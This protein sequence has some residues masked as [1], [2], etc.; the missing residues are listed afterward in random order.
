MMSNQIYT[1]TK[2]TIQAVF[3][4]CKGVFNNT[5]YFGQGHNFLTFCPLVTLLLN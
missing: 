3:G 1:G 4:L 2:D 5:R